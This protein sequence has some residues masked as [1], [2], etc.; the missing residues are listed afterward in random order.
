VQIPVPRNI[1]L[2]KELAYN[3]SSRCEPSKQK[4][5]HRALFVRRCQSDPLVRP[6]RYEKSRSITATWGSYC[7]TAKGKGTHCRAVGSIF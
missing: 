4:E 1:S 6:R 7:R 5:Y 3:L 2:R